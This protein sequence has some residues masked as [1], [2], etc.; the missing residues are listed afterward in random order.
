MPTTKYRSGDFTIS[1]ITLENWNASEQTN[2]LLIVDEICIE[3]SIF[4]PCIYGYVDITD[5]VGLH[6][7]FPIFGG[8][9]YWGATLLSVC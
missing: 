8:L 4:V 1:E 9:T 7:E 6:V 3:E 5:T 2:I